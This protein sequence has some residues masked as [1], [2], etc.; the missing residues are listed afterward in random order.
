MKK[1]QTILQRT[2][3][4][5]DKVLNLGL[6]EGAQRYSTKRAYINSQA[7][8]PRIDA[9]EYDR[10]AMMEKARWGEANCA[11]AQRIL[12]VFEMYTVGANGTPIIP[13]SSN[14]TWNDAARQVFDEWSLFPAIDCPHALSTMQSLVAR[15]WGVD[16]ESFIWKTYGKEPKLRPRIQVIESHRVGS[17]PS[18]PRDGNL[19]GI[20]YDENGRPLYYWVNTGWTSEKWQK[21]DARNLIHVF[22]PSR[23]GQPRGI[24]FFHSVLNALQDYKE[25]KDLEMIAA[26][27]AAEISRAIYNES[28]ELES[29][30]AWREDS[31][32]AAEDADGTVREKTYQ[33]KLGGRVV[34]LK[35]GE[36]LEQFL[37]NR[38]SPATQ[39]HWDI[40]VTDICLG[41]G[42][43]KILVYP[44]S[45]QG[46]V[47][48]AD[49]DAAAAFF[50]SR[51]AVLSKV[52]REIW[53]WVI[54]WSM[55]YDERLLNPPKDWTNI[56]IVPPRAVNVDVGRNSA[57]MLAELEAGTTT[58]AD[59]Y[60]ALGK[61][62]RDALRQRKAEK[63]YIASLGMTPQEA[64]PQTP[65]QP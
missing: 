59:I 37:T 10:T 48:R 49:L 42:I 18:N 51:S 45:M 12:D 31:D 25:L 3:R 9:T 35:S 14:P 57:A 39:A 30:A 21:I 53:L 50:R 28:G 2:A 58:L 46:T 52:W 36:K 41:F 22:E 13:C 61:D 5:L 33:D 23:P 26:K 54:G 8:D 15:R 6:Y 7:S 55:A 44:Q 17:P 1:R 47:T 38:P 4:Y 60:G 29:E 16:G 24:T 64:A 27:D 43:P 40:T 20:K 56:T 11:V 19:D 34:V 65:P 63:D 62:W 32:E